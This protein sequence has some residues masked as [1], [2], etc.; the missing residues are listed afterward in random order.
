MT[1]INKNLYTDKQF[2]I[3]AKYGKNF[4]HKKINI[5]FLNSSVRSINT[6][7]VLYMP[8]SKNIS[9]GKNISLTDEEA[10]KLLSGLEKIKND[11]EEMSAS[12]WIEQNLSSYTEAFPN[13]DHFKRTTNENSGDSVK[14]LKQNLEDFFRDLSSLNKDEMEIFDKMLSSMP[15]DTIDEKRL[16][17]LLLFAKHLGVGDKV[18]V[19][20]SGKETLEISESLFSYDK[21]I[22]NINT[23]KF[24]LDKALEF[25]KEHKDA[26]EISTG[27]VGGILMYRSIMKAYDRR[28]LPD[29]S[30]FKSDASRLKAVEEGLR[31][32]RLFATWG[33]LVVMTGIFGIKYIYKP[34][35][36]VIVN[37][38][39]SNTSSLSSNNIN[40]SIMVLF[41]QFKKLNKWFKLLII[42]LLTPVLFLILIYIVIPIRGEIFKYMNYIVFIVGGLIISYFIMKLYLIEKFKKYNEK[43]KLYKYIPGFIKKEILNLYEISQL[44]LVG[45]SFIVNNIVFTLLCVIILFLI[46]IIIILL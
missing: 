36:S 1:N 22:I 35:T 31:N 26:V 9:D 29:L 15:G 40:S 45:I 33:S 4:Y 28:Y 10:D 20:S 34:N 27:A 43:P 24:S 23:N 7:S 18:S 5:F 14:V 44:D 3:L 32:R 17:F 2:S 11:S 6:T 46:Y 37:V 21:G 38:N 8:N 39:V 41:S 16:S 25:I 13:L 19:I 30:S 12:E 42:L